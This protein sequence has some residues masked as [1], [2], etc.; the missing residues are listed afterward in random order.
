MDHLQEELEVFIEDL[1]VE[2]GDVEY[3]VGQ[4]SSNFNEICMHR[5]LFRAVF[6]GPSAVERAV[7]ATSWWPAGGMAWW[8]EREACCRRR[9]PACNPPPP[10]APNQPRSP[11]C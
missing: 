8:R 10:P 2:G 9:N 7:E 3:S 11:A 6:G 5:C 4:T 1:D